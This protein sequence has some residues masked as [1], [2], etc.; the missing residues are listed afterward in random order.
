MQVKRRRLM[1]QNAA[2]AVLP[3]FLAEYALSSLVHLLAHHPQF[4]MRHAALAEM[5]RFECRVGFI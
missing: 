2:K 5:Q 4:S 3:N 1:T